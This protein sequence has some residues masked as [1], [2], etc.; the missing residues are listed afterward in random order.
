[1]FRFILNIVSLVSIFLLAYSCSAPTDVS[2]IDDFDNSFSPLKV[3]IV[4]QYFSFS[5]SSYQNNMIVGR[6]IR[7]DGQEV[8]IGKSFT[9]L[10]PN[11]IHYYY[12]FIGDGFLYTTSLI[13]RNV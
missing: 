8:F 13:K 10:S 7:E 6:A 4:K 5:D 2:E 3:G 11:T 12:Q 1:M 9:S